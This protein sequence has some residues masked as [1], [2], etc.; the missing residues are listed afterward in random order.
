MS[1]MTRFIESAG[2]LT[3]SFARV[4]SGRG[5]PQSMT[6]G[7]CSAVEVVR[8]VL[9][10][11]SPLA[12]WSASATHGRIVLEIRVRASGRVGRRGKEKVWMGAVPTTP[13]AEAIEGA[14]HYER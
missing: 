9:D 4:E 13:I 10:C 5:L 3:S 7:G 11:A 6:R 1:K 14:R 8:Q 2:R 12:L